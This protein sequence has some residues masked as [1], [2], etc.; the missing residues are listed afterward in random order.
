MPYTPDAMGYQKYVDEKKRFDD[1]A[2]DV[3]TCYAAFRKHCPRPQMV[4]QIVGPWQNDDD[5]P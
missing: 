1:Y 2:T 5:P 3:R 4:F